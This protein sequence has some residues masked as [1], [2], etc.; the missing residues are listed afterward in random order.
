MKKRF[1]AFVFVIL[2][3]SLVVLSGCGNYG[4]FYSLTEA[5]EEGLITYEDL[6]SIA[7]YKNG[8]TRRNETLMGED[9]EPIPKEPLDEEVEWRIKET[10]AEKWRKKGKEELKSK[11]K[12]LKEGDPLD[13]ILLSVYKAELNASVDDVTI[14][15]Y[16]GT[17]GDC[18]AVMMEDAFSSYATAI[19]FDEIAGVILHYSDGNQIKVYIDKE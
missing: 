2:T 8:G 9:Y 6:L 14:R 7:Y 3:V 4:T 16:Y 11:G 19:W 1:L 18:I 12:E 15:G 5:Y 10:V 17:Y 13:E